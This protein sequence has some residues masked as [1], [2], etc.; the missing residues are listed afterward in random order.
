MT[1]R[2]YENVLVKDLKDQCIGIDIKQKVKIE[3][4][5]TSIDISSNHTL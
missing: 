3:I 1:A 4:G 5:Q 2:N